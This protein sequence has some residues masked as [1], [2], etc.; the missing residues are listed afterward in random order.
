MVLGA[1]LELGYVNHALDENHWNGELKGI[2]GWRSG[3]W[4]LATNA[5]IDFKVSG[6]VKAPTELQIASKIA[7]AISPKTSIGFESYNGV[8][9]LAHPSAFDHNDQAIYAVIDTSLGD[10][11]L[12]IGAGYGYGDP[13]DHFI[14]KAVIG[15]P[16]G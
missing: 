14:L 1:N 3:K 5:N 12:N 9:R 4:T 13:E 15:V 8:G 16:I 7:Y 11:D 10:W 6:P 2:L